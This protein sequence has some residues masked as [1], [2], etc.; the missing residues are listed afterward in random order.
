MFELL[1]I[2]ILPFECTNYED[3]SLKKIQEDV[4]NKES[5]Q[6]QVQL[7]NYLKI[8]LIKKKIRK[9]DLIHLI[10]ML[11]NIKNYKINFL[12]QNQK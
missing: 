6:D 7:N 1:K 8:R 10:Q 12:I 11:L 9:L 2:K 4:F 3:R 5:K